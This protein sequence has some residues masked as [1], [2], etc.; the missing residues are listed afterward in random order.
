MAPEILGKNYH[1]KCDLWS[2]GVLLYFML[3]GTLPFANNV[4]SLLREQ[5]KKAEFTFPKDKKLSEESKSLIKALLN[6][7]PDERL[8]ASQALD[9][10]WFAI[11]LT[12][13]PFKNLSSLTNYFKLDKI[14]KMILACVATH[15]SKISKEESKNQICE[16]A[17]VKKDNKKETNEKNIK[18]NEKKSIDDA[19]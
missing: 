17:E 19:V 3:V 4:E 5:I 14:Q 11:N 13:K 15:V 1:E 6:P 9:H 8:T 18:K 16:F 2:A 7:K 10:P 12:L